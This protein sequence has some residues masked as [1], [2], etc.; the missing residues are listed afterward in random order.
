MMRE[1]YDYVEGLVTNEFGSLLSHAWNVDENGNHID[2]SVDENYLL[3]YWGI[4][5]PEELVQDV[6][7][8]NG[9]ISY[10]VLPFIN[11]VEY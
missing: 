2:F 3:T 6:G 1:G 10:C 4:I 7:N 9:E 8:E 5:L 11:I